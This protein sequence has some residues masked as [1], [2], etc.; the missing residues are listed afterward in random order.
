MKLPEHVTFSFLLAQFGVQQEYGAVGTA[1]LILAGNLPDLDGLTVLG[2]WECHR[3]YHR[4]TGHGLPVTL[5][6][7]PLLAL[8]G[9]ALLGWPAFVPLWLWFQLAVLLHLISD[10]LFYRWP[11]QL[12]W[13]LSTRGV[14]F[15]L[16]PW[17]DLVPTALL[18]GGT[19]LALTWPG[20]TVAGGSLGLLALYVGWRAFLSSEEESGARWLTGGWARGSP[21]L[22]RW[23]TGDFVT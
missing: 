18:Y 7:A 6:G 4:V 2:G 22:C 9:A 10:F 19:A 8:F 13:P 11:V 21:R 20:P 12:L 5:V 1:L 16:V 3:K 14:G 23:L 15:G 17:N